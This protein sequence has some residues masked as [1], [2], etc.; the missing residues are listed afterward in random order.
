M[1]SWWGDVQRYS[2]V[3]TSSFVNNVQTDETTLLKTSEGSIEASCWIIRKSYKF[4]HINGYVRENRKKMKIK[5]HTFQHSYNILQRRQGSIKHFNICIE[6][7]ICWPWKWKCNTEEEIKD[8]FKNQKISSISYISQVSVTFRAKIDV[9][10]NMIYQDANLW[11]E[12]SDIRIG[13]R[14]TWKIH[15][16]PLSNS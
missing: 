12:F 5:T 15:N 7:G 8:L 9:T 10:Q 13:I 4:N 6:I 16:D 2:Q 3:H 1:R 14:T 11:W